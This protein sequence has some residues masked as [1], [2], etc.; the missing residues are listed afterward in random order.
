MLI[1]K[2]FGL[3]RKM[4]R[5][6]ITMTSFP[7]HQQLVNSKWWPVS[8][9]TSAH[10]ILPQ[11]CK[12]GN[13][14]S[15][16]L[17]LRTFRLEEEKSPYTW[18]RNEDL[19]HVHCRSARTTTWPQVWNQIVCPLLNLQVWGKNAYRHKMQPSSLRESKWSNPIKTILGCVSAFC[20]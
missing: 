20:Q 12:V 19:G 4:P 18:W 9:R 1:K 16:H 14:H 8:P 7:Y 15:S 17:Q 10:L 3:H 11:L 2:S 5:Q 6:A 13:C